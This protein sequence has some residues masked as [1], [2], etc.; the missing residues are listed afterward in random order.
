MNNIIDDKKFNI[1]WYVDYLKTSH[2][3]PAVVSRFL[4]DIDAEHGKIAKMTIMRGKVH[5]YLGMNI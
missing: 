1:L 4:T 5:N 2:V 3:D